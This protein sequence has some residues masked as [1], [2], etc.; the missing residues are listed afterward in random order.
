MTVWLQR[1]DLSSEDLED[2]SMESVISI[3]KDFD[4]KAESQKAE[5]ARKSGHDFCMAGIGMIHEDGQILHVLPANDET[6][7]CHYHYPVKQRR[8]LGIIGK[9]SRQQTIS[10]KGVAEKDLL[11]TIR[12]HYQG[13]HGQ[14]MNRLA[15]MATRI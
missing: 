4:W 7:M 3:L 6:S 1:H 14:V 13:N 15:Q 12:A 8:I 9:K 10:F 2:T 5:D 11:S